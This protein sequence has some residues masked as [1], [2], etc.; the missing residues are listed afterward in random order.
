[1]TPSTLT[2]PITVIP[3]LARLS[4]GLS[5]MASIAYKLDQ[6]VSMVAHLE[7]MQRRP[8]RPNSRSLTKQPDQ[9]LYK[10][11]ETTGGWR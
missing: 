7:A 5:E 1:M 10:P 9:I 2:R 4:S 8:A 3:D 6:L 11:S